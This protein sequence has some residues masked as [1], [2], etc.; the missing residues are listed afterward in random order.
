MRI[1]WF[2]YLCFFFI[3]FLLKNKSIFLHA[4][5]IK[6]QDI[7][8]GMILAGQELEPRATWEFDADVLVLHHPTTISSKYQAMGM[9][10]LVTQW[11]FQAKKLL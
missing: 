6:R 9:R 5:Q 10:Y 2:Y 3:L 4:S 11:L 1:S 8:K 7:R